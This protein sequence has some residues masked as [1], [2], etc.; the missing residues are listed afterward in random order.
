[1]VFRSDRSQTGGTGRLALGH[2]RG[3]ARAG[4]GLQL[5]GVV[6]RSR[7]AGGRGGL[8]IGELTG[9][10]TTDPVVRA[11]RRRVVALAAQVA[12]DDVAVHHD[13][14]GVVRDRHVATEVVHVGAVVDQ[15][16]AADLHR[17]VAVPGGRAVDL[18]A[19]DHRAVR[20][21]LDRERLGDRG[22]DQ[23][24]VGG[25]VPGDRAGDLAAADVQLAGDRLHVLGDRAVLEVGER[26]DR[27]VGRGLTGVAGGQAG[28]AERDA[29]AA[30]AGHPPGDAGVVGV[31][32][33]VLGHH[34]STLEDAVGDHQVGA[35]LHGHLALHGGA[36]QDTRLAGRH[37]E[38]AGHG[39]GAPGPDAA[40]H[41]VGR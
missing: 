12:P 5:G 7:P 32:V 41:Q 14:T 39:D 19:A 30:L 35:G 25:A 33:A 40:G 24:G 38:I 27:L 31:E 26:H 28:R 23:V 4:L 11:G 20:A 3:L 29:V 10:L 34:D 8:Q 22:V 17:A 6:L 1:F 37:D 13:P 15:T 16:A 36:L 18:A 2:R 21:V 9:L